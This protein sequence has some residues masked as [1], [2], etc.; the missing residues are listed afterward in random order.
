MKAALVGVILIGFLGVVITIQQSHAQVTTTTSSP[1]KDY[2]N[3]L[4]NNTSLVGNK[5][6]VDYESPHTLILNLKSNLMN[7]AGQVI[8][9]A[10]QKGYG[11][12]SVTTYI[13]PYETAPGVKIFHTI[14]MSKN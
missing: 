2:A 12:E 13:V 8:D 9:F 14:F 10:K 1:V 7:L 4:Q 11:F 6:I 5:V 3:S